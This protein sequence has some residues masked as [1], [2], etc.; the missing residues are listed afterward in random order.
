MRRTLFVMSYLTHWLCWHWRLETESH[1]WP[2]TT[3]LDSG[4]EQINTDV[5]HSPMSTWRTPALMSPLQTWI[6]R[7]LGWG[8]L[9]FNSILSI[10]PQNS[11]FLQ[12]CIRGGYQTEPED[13]KTVP[14]SGNSNR[15]QWEIPQYWA[16]EGEENTVRDKQGNPEHL[17]Q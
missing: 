6:F 15:P 5:S 13:R 9:R 14:V 17:L 11:L 10:N 12:K 8:V 16:G 2:V 3:T 1:T 4:G 7:F